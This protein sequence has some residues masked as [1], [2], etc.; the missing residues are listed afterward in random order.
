VGEVRALRA[1]LLLF[2][3]V[4]GLKVNFHKSMLTGINISDS[5]LAA[6]TLV[7]NCRVGKVSFV[8]LVLSVG[9][10]AR[11][12][13]FLE[14]ILTRIATRLSGWKNRFLSF[15]SRLIL[16]KFVLYSLPIYPFSFF[17]ASSGIIS[18]I[19]SFFN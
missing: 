19:E 17:K 14:P 10:D 12:L 15:G 2:E 18:A 8:Y 4:S 7:L 5:W 9:G 13:F 6:A 1:V 11:R 16:I 3:S